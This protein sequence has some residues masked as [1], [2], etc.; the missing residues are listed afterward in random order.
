MFSTKHKLRLAGAFAVLAIL[1]LAVGCRG[2]F[3]NPTVTSLAIGPANLSLA[4]SESFQMSATATYS[5]GSTSNA[6]GNAV[7]LSS[8]ISVAT[9][10]SPGDLTAVSLTEL[11]A[12]GSLPGTTTVSASIGTVTSS[13]QTV[14]VCPVVQT[15]A[16]TADGSSSSASEPSD[17]VVQFVAEATFN[18]VSGKQNVSSSV[19]WTISNTSVIPSITSTGSGALFATGTVASNEDGMSTNVS[20]SLCNFPSNTVTVTAST[21]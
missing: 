1:A 10:P 13:S 2:F 12:Q 4:P 5:D 8:D 7:W 18:G 11:E 17:T 3:V 19:S 6:T 14:N 9:F 15:L 20:A 16:I 21:P